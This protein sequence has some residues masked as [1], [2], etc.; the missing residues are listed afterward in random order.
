MRYVLE[1]PWLFGFLFGWRG[2]TFCIFPNVWRRSYGPCL[3]EDRR[4]LR[5]SKL[6]V[7]Y[8]SPLPH[9][10]VTNPHG[11]CS[12]WRAVFTAEPLCEMSVGEWFTEIVVPVSG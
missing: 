4:P 2:H 7:S 9:I 1:C 3:A 5:G 8:E 6:E 12:T 10:E 11:R